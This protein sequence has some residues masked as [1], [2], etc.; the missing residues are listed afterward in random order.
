MCANLLL[1]LLYI[2]LF[3]ATLSEII[4]ETI[5]DLLEIGDFSNISLKQFHLSLDPEFV[6]IK[7]INRLL[8]RAMHHLIKNTMQYSKSK[9]KIFIDGKINKEK[10]QIVLTTLNQSENNIDIDLVKSYYEVYSDN[11]NDRTAYPPNGTNSNT[12]HIRNRHVSSSGKSTNSFMTKVSDFF[13]HKLTGKSSFFEKGYGLKIGTYIFMIF[14]S[15]PLH[16]FEMK[17]FFYIFN[18]ML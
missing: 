14:I 16:S 10:N 18:V 12:N 13:K 3:I 2:Y 11:N 9:E 7:Y 1:I 4:H 17:I 6:S 15:L 5:L 8:P